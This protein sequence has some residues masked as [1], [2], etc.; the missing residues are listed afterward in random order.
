MS[1]RAQAGRRTAALAATLILLALTGCGSSAGS[2]PGTA[3][4]SIGAG[5][6]GPSALR[7]SVYAHGPINTAAFTIDPS[8]RLWVA[9]A[10]LEE[11]THDGVYLISAAGAPAVRVISGLDDPLGLA[12]H[13]GRL[14]VASVG[15]V[16]AYW[17]L[18]GRTFSRHTQILRGPLAGG[19]NNG[20]VMAPD[21][22]FIMGITASCDHCNPQSRWSGSVVSFLPD[23]SDL[24]LYASRVR[25]PVGLEFFPGTSDLFATINQRDDLGARTPGDWLAEI[26]E[27]Q[28]WGFPYCWGEGGSVCDGVPHPVAVLDKHAA[29]GSVAIATGQ[30]GASVG[31]AAL[32]SEWQSAKVQRVALTRTTTGYAGV[33]SPFIT[34]IT[35]PLAAVLAPDGSLL[36]GD[37]Q[38]GTIY[39]ISRG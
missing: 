14:Y 12:W 11:H 37:W 10:G 15:R 16:D 3:L 24:R 9:A 32:V 30:L 31:T 2:S 13:D 8:G 4:V 23:G 18:N 25:A 29:V 39:R 5:L 33:V 34:G 20:L 26:S 27:G 21:G 17:S 36:L 6:K 19:E 7:A 22:R 28:D 35:H 1:Q 38:T